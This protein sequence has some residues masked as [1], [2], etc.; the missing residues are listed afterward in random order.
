MDLFDLTIIG[1]GPTGLFAA[2]YSGL[3]RMRTKIIDALPQLG[4]Q[5]T[6][7]YPEKYIYDVAGFPKVLAKDLASDLIGQALQ[8]GPE[9]CVGE[10]ITAM[11]TLAENGGR[12]FKLTND[13]GRDHYTK[14]ILLTV[15][16]G[17][18][19]PRKLDLPDAKRFEGNGVLYFIQ[20]KSVL[21]DKKLLIVGGGDSAV[22]W[23]LNLDGVA[24]EITLIHRR[25]QFRA[26]EDSVKKLF[27]S[28]ARVKLFYELKA[29]HG[30]TQ[31]E[32]ATIYH[33]RTKEEETLPVDCI[34]LNLGFI[35][36]LGAIKDWGLEIEKNDVKVST[37]METNIP[38]I[39]AAGDIVVYPGKLKLIATGFGEAAI[40]VN[41]IKS[42]T[43]PAAKFFP[44]HS[45]DMAP[46]PGSKKL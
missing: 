38:G 27:Q 43:D 14:A 34:L 9:V 26:H 44:G 15:G 39:Y 17:A 6:A 10:K 23:V 22:D 28:S 19:A 30:N 21:E 7:L 25:D 35:A 8:Y 13:T 42:Y 37:K 3:R 46:P 11:Q 41:A 5:L 4:G 40:A 29:V 2:Y 45:S 33:N 20:A 31:V 32:A 36:S 18:F 24:K 1:G 16:I 12:I